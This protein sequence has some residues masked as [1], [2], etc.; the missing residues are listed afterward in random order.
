[1]TEKLNAELIEREARYQIE[2]NRL[3]EQLSE[4]TM[5]YD[6]L[7]TLTSGFSVTHIPVDDTQVQREAVTQT[8]GMGNIFK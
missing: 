4:L 3:R 6:A 2:I 8:L 1:M 7:R 5:R